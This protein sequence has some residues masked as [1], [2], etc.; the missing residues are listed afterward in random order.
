MPLPFPRKSFDRL[1]KRLAQGAT[2]SPDDLQM[3]EAAYVEYDKCL[4]VV[5][6][7]LEAMGFS[8]AVP[9]LKSTDTLIDK[10]RRSPHTA[11]SAINDVAGVR[12][13][14]G[15]GSVKIPAGTTIAGGW[16]LRE[17][18]LAAPGRYAQ[19]LVANVIPQAFAR[20][21]WPKDPKVID[22]RAE[23]A[24]SH[25]YRAVHVIVFPEGL[26]VEIQIRTPLQHSWAEISERLGD[27]WGRG[28]RYGKGPDNPDEPVAP[29]TTF[30]RADIVRVLS[31]LSERVH[32]YERSAETVE[33]LEVAASFAQAGEEASTEVLS[34]LASARTNLDSSHRELRD[35]L[36]AL[37]SAL[38]L[39]GEPRQ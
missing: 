20:F 27:R 30:S 6:R 35:I 10:L 26:P 11:L 5:R 32:S 8:P 33:Q 7:N 18:V 17:D 15:S 12:I 28:L 34:Q 22:R 21:S 1:G 3:L 19:T 37:K 16:S 23:G 9:R 25:G 39:S 31:I 36:D 2:V 29:G 24:D 38:D 13:V 14:L 4:Q